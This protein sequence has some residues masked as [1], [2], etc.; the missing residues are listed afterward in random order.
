[1]STEQRDLIEWARRQVREPVEPVIFAAGDNSTLFVLAGALRRWFLKIAQDLRDEVD[2]LRWIQERAPV[3]RIV[4]YRPSGSLD[5]MV[6][7]ALPGK[8]LAELC[9]VWPADQVTQKLA[10]ALRAF[11]AID[12]AH[13][14]FG[15]QSPGH[16]LVHGDACLPNIL[17]DESMGDL[18]GFVDLGE[19]RV[20]RPDVDLSAGVWSLEYNMGAGHG[21]NLLQRYGLTDADESTVL[22]LCDMYRSRP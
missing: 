8:S 4:A 15:E 20:D 16:V 14:P 19:M 17:F 12:A 5:G 22:S 6:M 13:C 18:T 9:G 2:R 1:M 3:P 10:A 7:T 21:L 11:H